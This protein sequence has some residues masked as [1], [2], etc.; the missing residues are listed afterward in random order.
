MILVYGGSFDPVHLGHV[1]LFWQARWQLAA[2]VCRWLPAGQ[3]PLKDKPGAS[4]EQRLAMLQLAS[5]SLNAAAGTQGF[6][7]DDRELRR[8]GPSFTC[9]TLAELRQE[10][11]AECPL[12]WLMGMD[13][14][15]QLS[16]WR[17]WQQ[18]TDWAHLLLLERPGHWQCPAPQAQWAQ[19][20]LCSLAELQQC[21]SG[22]IGLLGNSPLGIAS[23]DIRQQIAQ[24]LRPVGLVPEAVEQYIQAQGL[25]FNVL[26]HS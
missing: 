25:Y 7:V 3:S 9:D 24:G 23:R 8:P 18:L 6:E 4:A 26:E 16:Q 17:H 19:A 10:L 2:Q 13:A 1:R 20:R 5:A 14:W 11:G 22:G 15:Q 12:V 21:P